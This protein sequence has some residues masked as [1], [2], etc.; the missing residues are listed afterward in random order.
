MAI[1]AI[2]M[3]I[4]VGASWGQRPGGRGIR[5]MRDA[6]LDRKR[7]AERHVERRAEGMWKGG[8]K[9]MWKGGP[10][11]FALVIGV[12]WKGWPK[13]C[14]GRRR[15]AEV[16]TYRALGLWSSEGGMMRLETLI[17]LR[18]LNSSFSRSNFSIR[19]VRAY[20]LIEIRQTAPC[21]EIRG[22]GISVN[23]AHPLPLRSGQGWQV[24]G[25]DA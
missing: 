1:L 17:E 13:A 18:F 10:K 16:H 22:D 20:P 6:S 24:S 7:R 8:P 12:A 15:A 25:S 9:G 23:R 11:A 4:F 5:P 14:P 19:V 2:N 3:A 21:R